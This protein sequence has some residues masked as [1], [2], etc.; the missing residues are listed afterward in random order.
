M[1]VGNLYRMNESYRT[2]YV[3]ESDLFLLLG[4][5]EI[6]NAVRKD[7][8]VYYRYTFRNITTG[9]PLVINHADSVFE[10]LDDLVTNDS[11]E[12]TKNNTLNRT[13]Q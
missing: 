7:C 6:P 12:T 8:P 9:E 11:S 13:E 3:D 5:V 2:Y 10:P 4:I 1:Q